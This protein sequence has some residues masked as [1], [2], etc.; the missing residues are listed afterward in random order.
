MGADEEVLPSGQ[1]RYILLNPEIKGHRCA[2]VGF[3]LN[4][5]HPGVLCLCGHSSCYHV[6]STETPPDKSEV[7]EL[8]R[9]V[10][11]LEGQLDRDNQMGIG[12]ALGQVVQRLGNLEE[13]FEASKGELSQDVKDCYGN[14]NR[15]WIS[16]DQLDK[17]QATSEHRYDERLDG[18][19]DALQRLNDRVMEID[20]AS[21][22]LE[23][24][25]EALEDRSNSSRSHHHQQQRPTSESERTRQWLSQYGGTLRPQPFSSPDHG[26]S[27]N[28]IW[29]RNL[30]PDP[31]ENTVD[32]ACVTTTHSSAALPFRKGY[33]RL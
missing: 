18:H 9:R 6:K 32:C 7:E 19:D 20:E 26:A 15:M 1:C 25:I 11:M 22:A 31:D 17:R 21:M 14:V 24:R 16:F 29:W 4:R 30:Y 33:Q 10:Q 12:N 28:S 2:C 8:R 5:T 13:Q 23:E 27:T 3:T